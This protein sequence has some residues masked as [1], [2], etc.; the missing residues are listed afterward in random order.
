MWDYTR[1]DHY[2]TII[3]TMTD[4]QY[5]GVNAGNVRHFLTICLQDF[6]KK[7]KKRYS[8]GYIN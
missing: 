8:N 3:V 1:C 7:K 6:W 2:N 5:S 4:I